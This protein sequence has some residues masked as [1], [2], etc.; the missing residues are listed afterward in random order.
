MDDL[1]WFVDDE[2]LQSH[3]NAVAARVINIL[4]WTVVPKTLQ[5]G[6]GSMAW[7]ASVNERSNLGGQR[8]A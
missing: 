1:H 5:S 6:H 4:S 2:N 7:Q 3:R 8:C